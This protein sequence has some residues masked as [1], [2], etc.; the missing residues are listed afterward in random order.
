MASYTNY[1]DTQWART[2]ATTLADHIRD[3]EE[4]MLR[5]FPMGALVDSQGRVSYNHV[6]MGFDWPVQYKLHSV[7][8]NTG[9]TAR[10]FVRTNLWK[11]AALPY[12]GYQAVD[13]ITKDELL[14]NRGEAA[15]VKV[16]ENMTMRLETSL[17]QGLGNQ[18]YIDGNASGNETC[19]HGLE[20]MFG[21]TQ[22][23]DVTSTTTP[24]GRTANA[25]DTVLYPNDTYAGLS[26]ILGNY[27][28]AI[29]SGQV[30]PNG[31][32]DAELD[33]WSPIVV[34]PKSTHADFPSATNTWAGQGD[35]VMRYAIIHSQRNTS[36]NGPVTTI[37]LARD[38]YLQ[39]LNLIDGKEQLNVTKGDTGDLWKLGF[40]NV[41]GFD[42]CEVT[43]DTAVSAS[44]GYGFNPKNIEIKCRQ[45]KFFNT[46]GPEYDIHT[47][48]WNC[49]VET[50]SNIRF[51]S[52]RNF[53]KIYEI[54]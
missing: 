40:R 38:Y 49:V 1:G 35:E 13:S 32:A 31:T 3:V 28:G 10:N 26:T 50:L 23:T 48:N 15:I 34:N 6:G 52:P 12:R 47:Q 5:N 25:A 36:E 22:T 18:Y 51:Q 24:A 2:L 43:W 33:F 27:G 4:A 11:T 29:E 39:F 46:E 42:G 19:W 30:W 45:D 54:V 8:G 37:V 20:S 17:K 21:G 9:A 41:V 44:R 53:F 7:E 16:F 14:A